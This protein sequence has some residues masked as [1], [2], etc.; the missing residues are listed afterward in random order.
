MA[1]PMLRWCCLGRRWVLACVD[2]G[3]RHGRGAAI[4]FTSSRKRG[5]SSVA[6]QPLITAQKSRKGE[7]K[8]AAVVGLEI[9]AQIS[10]NSKLFSGSQVRFA[11]PPNSLVSFFDASLPGTLPNK[12]SPS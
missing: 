3:S 4:G 12:D 9:H 10:S 6:Q 8:W 7:H 2:S 1:A 11:A 5:Q